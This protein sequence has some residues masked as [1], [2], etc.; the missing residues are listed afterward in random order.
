MATL[1]NLHNNRF[2]YFMAN[3]S[4]FSG[5]PPPKLGPL[6]QKNYLF[7]ILVEKAIYPVNSIFTGGI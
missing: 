2:A 3:F 7:G 1:N 4:K 5:F 6:W